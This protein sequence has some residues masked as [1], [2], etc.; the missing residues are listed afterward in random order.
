MS[1]RA[2]SPKLAEAATEADQQRGQAEKS[3]KRF[4]H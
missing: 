4:R 2:F 1:E 3:S